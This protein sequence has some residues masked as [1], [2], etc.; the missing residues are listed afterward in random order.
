MSSTR[1]LYFLP[2]EG[3]SG[4]RVMPSPPFVLS[5]GFGVGTRDT[6]SLV[7]APAQLRE[8]GKLLDADDAVVEGGLEAL[9]HGIGQDD[10]DHDRQDV[11]DLPCQLEDDDGRGHRVG[12]STRQCGRPCG[13]PQE[14]QGGGLSGIAHQA[15]SPSWVPPS[16][17]STTSGALGTIRGRPQWRHHSQ[18]RGSSPQLWGSISK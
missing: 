13:H 11:R 18:F 4:L 5:E 9:G 15:M 7:V 6:N 17:A 2:R 8:V 14:T 3:N 16:R 10:S 1:T 12:D